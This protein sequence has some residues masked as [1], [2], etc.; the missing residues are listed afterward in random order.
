MR[1]GIFV[2]T[3]AL[4]IFVSVPA[5]AE[6]IP[7]QG[8]SESELRGKCNAGEGNSFIGSNNGNSAY[9]CVLASGTVIA[10]GG[11]GDH[12]TCTVSR[13]APGKDP[14]RRPNIKHLPL[15]PAR[16]P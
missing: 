2:A 14:R 7:A 4:A 16:R 12:N 10:C 3:T 5:I 1:Q 6:E 15:A 11:D 8:N 13:H 9:A